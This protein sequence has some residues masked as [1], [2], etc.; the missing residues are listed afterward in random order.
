M[1]HYVISYHIHKAELQ[2]VYDNE[3][4]CTRNQLLVNQIDSFVAY[5]SC[6]RIQV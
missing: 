4:F 5:C 6:T 2:Y 3:T 1:Q